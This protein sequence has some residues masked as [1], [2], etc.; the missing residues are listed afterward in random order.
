MN[1]VSPMEAF[2]MR[3]LLVPV[4]A[5]LVVALFAGCSFESNVPDSGGDDGNT[6]GDQ[7][8]SYPPP[9]YGSSYGD[10]AENFQVELVSCNGDTGMGRAWR[11]EEY[12][13]TNAILIT[14]HA[15][16]CVYC[17]QQATTMDDD[18]NPYLN[19]GLEV[20]LLITEDP[21]GVTTRQTLLDYACKYS[22]DYGFSFPVGIDPGGA[23]TGQY[24]DGVPLNML[25]DKKMEIRYKITGLLPEEGILEGNIEG[26]INE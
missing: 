5:G 21:R 6:G 15:G 14:V 18:L 13:G 10:T 24:F 20:M 16:W 7:A 22:S 2:M 9:P 8:P 3:K 1:R 12:L 19:H 23:A 25:L 26:L 17:K 4:L 11:L